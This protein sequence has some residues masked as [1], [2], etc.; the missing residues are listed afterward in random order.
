MTGR[1]LLTD[2]VTVLRA[3]GR[4]LAKAIR[5]DYTID[6]YDSARLFDLF[7]VPVDGLDKHLKLLD[8]LSNRSDCCV[9][10]G[11]I[12]DPA[13]TRGVRRLVHPD[14]ETGDEPTLIDAPRR[15]LALDL[16]GLERPAIIAASDLASCA[17]IAIRALPIQ[18]QDVACIA[19]ATAGHGIKPGIRMRLWF[20]LGRA[21][22]GIELRRWLRGAPVDHSV[23]G[24]G[25][26]I[27]T[28]TP[29]FHAGAQDPL[30]ERIVVLHGANE[31]VPVPSSSTLM[32]PPRRPIM[33]MT[34]NGGGI[35]RYGFAALCAATARVTRAADGARHP[36]LLAEATGLADLVSRNHLTAK[37][38]ADAL[39]GAAGRA[40]LPEQEAA[41]VIAWALARL[42][43]QR[44]GATS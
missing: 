41:D 4:R 35:S 28:A 15:W 37:A 1:G 5:S 38:V 27:Y 16:D 30:G 13:N 8:A 36:T 31:V 12:A 21:T 17:A 14:N 26:M 2:S 29:V 44:A 34:V 11:A 43:G 19:Q 3:R 39:C 6:D 24:P 18:F 25:Q 20:W 42:S 10:R 33:E 23:F 7:A 9:V 40:G 22:T 32:T